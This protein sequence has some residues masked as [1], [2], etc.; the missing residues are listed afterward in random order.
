MKILHIWNTAGVPQTIAKIQREIGLEADLIVRDGYDAFN[1]LDLIDPSIKLTIVKGP[2]KLFKMKVLLLAWKYDILHIHAVDEIVPLIRKIYP[3]KKIVL[4]YHGRDIRDRWDEKKNRYSKADIITVATPDLMNGAPKNVLFVGNTVD[5]FHWIRKNG[6]FPKS[7]IYV[8][9][10]K[11][12]YMATSLIKA[13]KVAKNIGIDFLH[14]LR[15]EDFIP[16]AYF[17]RFLELFEFFIDIKNKEGTDEIVQARGMTALQALSLGLKV[18]DNNN[19]ITFQL[20]PEHSPIT[21]RETWS[22]IYGEL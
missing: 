9:S 19:V 22:K 10:E 11:G 21:I 18:I 7:A 14:V 5:M 8:N 15:R 4:T 17:P 20:P 16:Y 12:D 13:R 3:R 1:F 2:A 6:Y